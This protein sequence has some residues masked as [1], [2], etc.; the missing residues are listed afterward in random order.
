MKK[1]KLSAVI[2]LYN[3]TNEYINTI[4]TIYKHI[5]KFYIIDNG[6]INNILPKLT[7]KIEYIKNNQNEGIAY[8][9]N[10]GAKCAI[11]DGYQWLLT[12]DQDSSISEK[13]II[14]LKN[15]ISKND[16]NKIGIISPYQDVETTE[17]IEQ[18]AIEEK[19]EVMTSGNIIN[20][21]VYQKVGGFKEWLFIDGVDIEYGMNLN[22]HGYK[23]IRLNYSKMKHC[24]G[25]TKIHSVFGRKIIC[26]NHNGLRRYYMVRNNLYIRD[27]Y[28]DVYPDYCKFL[29]DV[30]KGQ[31]KRVIAFEKNKI[32]KILYMYK[33]YKDYKRGIK[34]KFRG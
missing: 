32:K 28:K 21:N 12:L 20:L 11:N 25:N 26:S 19:L 31:L 2:V 1:F 8:A 27:M 7:K 13:N 10:K 24:L 15:Y 9:L 14:D 18:E 6:N 34:G 30:Q 22:K 33:G 3:P 29:I 4:K 23:V 16:T 17:V 5:D